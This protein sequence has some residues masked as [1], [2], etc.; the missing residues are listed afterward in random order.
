MKIFCPRGVGFSSYLGLSYI[1]NHS[2][3]K[4]PIYA[5]KSNRLKTLDVLHMENVS[6]PQIQ[7]SSK[8]ERKS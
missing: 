7:Q 3:K 8:Y 5:T 1:G 2:V 4:Q 6:H